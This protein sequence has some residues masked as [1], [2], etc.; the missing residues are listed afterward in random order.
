MT[1]LVIIASLCFTLNKFFLVNNEAIQIPK[2]ISWFFGFLGALLF[3]IYFYKTDSL[4]L[5][6]LEIGLLLLTL[7]R[8]VSTEKNKTIENVLG[9]VVLLVLG[10]QFYVTYI[11][12]LGTLQFVASVFMLWGTYRMIRD[13]FISGFL[14]YGL[15]HLFTARYGYRMDLEIFWKFQM[16]QAVICLFGLWGTEK[17]FYLQKK[18]ELSIQITFLFSFSLF[19]GH[20]CKFVDKLLTFI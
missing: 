15:G 16:I 11:G 3:I 10:I 5:S 6:T 19:I 12:L 17:E 14:L 13:N 9:F 2:Q 4:I 1:V 7:Y 20:I 18:L 8:T